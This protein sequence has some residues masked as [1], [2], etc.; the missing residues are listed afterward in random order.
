MQHEKCRGLCLFPLLQ[1]RQQPQPPGL[2]AESGLRRQQIPRAG[3]RPPGTGQGR[4]PHQFRTEILLPQLLLA[5]RGQEN[6]LAALFRPGRAAMA[7]EIHIHQS[8][9]FSTVGRPQNTR[10]TRAACLASSAAP[11]RIRRPRDLT[12]SAAKPWPGRY[13]WPGEIWR[14]QNPKGSGAEQSS[15]PCKA[16]PD[17]PGAPC[18]RE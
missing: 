8:A 3:S 18:R 7:Q 1:G 5:L 10:I 13:S 11:P 2:P 6:A 14:W 15:D 12:P 17:S 16:V 9:P 4:H